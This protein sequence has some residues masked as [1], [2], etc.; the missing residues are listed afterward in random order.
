MDTALSGEYV[1]NGCSPADFAQAVGDIAP[2]MR[3]RLAEIYRPMASALADELNLW[4]IPGGIPGEYTFP[5]LP[6]HIAKIDAEVQSWI[7]HHGL[8]P[9]GR[10]Y[11]HPRLAHHVYAIL[12]D[13]PVEV[14]RVQILWWERIIRHDDSTVEPGL[15]TASFPSE[16]DQILR[17]RVLPGEPDRHHLAFLDLRDAIADIDGGP[18]LLPTMADEAVALLQGSLTEQHYRTTG[19]VPTLRQYL[20]YAA[21]LI[22]IKDTIALGRLAPGGLLPGE[23]P[24]A[25]LPPL[26]RLATDIIRLTNDVIGA[27][28]ESVEGS[29]TVFAAMAA[30]YDLAPADAARAVLA[31]IDVLM[32][33]FQHTIDEILPECPPK[34][35]R[36][37]VLLQRR[38][39]AAYAWDL[40]VISTRYDPATRRRE[41]R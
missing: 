31:L 4:P 14:L 26:W 34:I 8:N 38:V 6:E 15:L 32:R 1:I 28:R 18:T 10:T 13:A 3:Q 23:I 30:Q 27:H 9:P 39:C 5:P 2:W 21:D 36:E 12:H 20:H 7:D 25:F 16:V 35:H 19:T 11:P 37:L 24:P 41:A 17:N 33:D 40:T 29:P 22:G